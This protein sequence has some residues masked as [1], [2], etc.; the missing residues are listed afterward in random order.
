MQRRLNKKG[1]ILV[2]IIGIITLLLISFIIFLIVYFCNISSVSKNKENKDFLINE[3]DTYYSISTKLKENNLIKSEFFYKLY[4]KLNKPNS[5][6]SGIHKL[7]ENMSV[8][9]L[10]NEISQGGYKKGE[11]I[12]FK[13]GLNMRQIAKIIA[14]NTSNSEDDVYSTLNDSEYIDSLIEKYWFITD[15]IKNENI[16]YSLEGYL[17]PN[18]YEFYKDEVTVKQIFN[19]ML[20]ETDKQLQP[21]K[22]DILNFKYSVHELLTLASIVELEGKTVSDRSEVAGV[23]YNRLNSGWSLGSDVTTYYGAKINMSDR[24]L[25][26]SELN[27]NNAYN[28]RSNFMAG[29]L[30]VGPICNP[31]ISSIKA[32]LYPK[33]TNYYY[34]VAD[35]NGKTYFTK[36]SSEHASIIAKL[37]REGL[38]YTY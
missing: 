25:Y 2:G 15:E 3:G 12:T 24:D 27:D 19:V 16:Y 37:K 33:Q 38:W 17:F 18:T 9:E 21:Y 36:T 6:K 10:V 26:V 13:E 31:S 32:A 23:F 11:M 20:D 14:D 8:K 35:K 29:K 28:T 7:N 5:L 4:I 22:D 1:K 34:F 30:P